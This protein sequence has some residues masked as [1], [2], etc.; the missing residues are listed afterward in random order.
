MDYS[1]SRGKP[2]KQRLDW[3]RETRIPEQR[4]VQ[5]PDNT[6]SSWV[7]AALAANRSCR[8]TRQPK[9]VEKETRLDK[10][11]RRHH[12]KGTSATT[13]PSAT[14]PTISGKKARLTSGSSGRVRS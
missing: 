12:H 9:D 2:F 11:V 7:D 10:H 1:A 6:A 14:A 4:P 8:W 13:L 3:F 5:F